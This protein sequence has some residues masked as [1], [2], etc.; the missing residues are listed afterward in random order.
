MKRITVLIALAVLAQGVSPHHAS[1]QTTEEEVLSV[2]SGLFDGM[3]TGNADLLKSL[4][5]ADALMTGTGMRDGSYNVTMN[6][7]DG[8]IES[9]SSYTGGEIDERFYDPKVY[10]SGPLA[11]VWTEYDLYVGGEF[12]HCGVDAFHF[13]LTDDGW[14][15][16]HLADTRVTTGCP[17][18]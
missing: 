15:I 2:V 5:H 13:A 16:V 3:R 4:F 12:R 8:W 14:K 17:T 10:V 9:I 6:P 18:R 1:T 11:S 7:P